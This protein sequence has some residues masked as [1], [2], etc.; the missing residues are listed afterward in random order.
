MKRECSICDNNLEVKEL[1]YEGYEIYRCGYCSHRQ[2]Y[3][4]PSDEEIHKYYSQQSDTIGNA[5]AFRNIEDYMENKHTFYKF[6]LR[7]LKQIFKFKLLQNNSLKFLE[8]G[9]GPGCFLAL[10]RDFYGF[11]NLTGIDISKQIID[12]G[13]KQLGIDLYCGDAGEME[14]YPNAPFDFVY[15]Y[16]S[17][18]HCKNPLK[19]VS[20]IYKNVVKGGEVFL[21]VPNYKG[22]FGR[23]SKERWYWI[24]PPSHIH[25]FTKQSMTCLLEKAG[26]KNYTVR[27]EIVSTSGALP[28]DIVRTFIAV[29]LKQRVGTLSKSM[30]STGYKKIFFA[31]TLSRII[32]SP[33]LLYMWLTDSFDSLNVYAKKE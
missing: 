31:D 8:V 29:A 1:S 3:P 27:T 21:S 30:V 5:N 11:T 17:L 23:L 4:I 25:Y 12:E 22:F 32:A 33:L 18:E 7:R 13:I 9:S 19:I 16:H 10:L 15:C 20:N 26:F 6:Y 24:L 28:A 2:L 14:E